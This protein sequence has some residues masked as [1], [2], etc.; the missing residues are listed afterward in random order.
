VISLEVNKELKVGFNWWAFFFNTVYY[1]GKGKIKKAALLAT[2]AW[3]PLF[4]LFV[5]IHCGRNANK[6]IENKEF[7]WG[8]AVG[9]GV[10]QFLIARFFI[11]AIKH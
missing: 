7:N 11:Y 5:A 2:V 4:G 9:V 10:F 8:S 3:F 6:E 1:A